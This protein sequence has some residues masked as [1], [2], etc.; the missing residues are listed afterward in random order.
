MFQVENK[1]LN[2]KL[3]NE[4]ESYLKALL[5]LEFVNLEFIMKRIVIKLYAII[6]SR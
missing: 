1:L 2:I 5:N 4:S 6:S 3:T